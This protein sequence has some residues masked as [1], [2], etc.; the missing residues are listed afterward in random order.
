MN[1]NVLL[2]NYVCNKKSVS[3]KWNKGYSDKINISM[4]IR[5]MLFYI[6]VK[7]IFI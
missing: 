7:N 6:F 5:N 1:F 4:F 3:M 2:N